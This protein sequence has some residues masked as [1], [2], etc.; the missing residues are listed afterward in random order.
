MDEEKNKLDT[1]CEQ[2]L[3]NV[4]NFIYLLYFFYLTILSLNVKRKQSVSSTGMLFPFNVEDLIKFKLDE[5]KEK[6]YLHFYRFPFFCYADIVKF[7][8]VCF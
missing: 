3:K 8:L 4:S 2:S 1:F 7:S 5:N 6:F